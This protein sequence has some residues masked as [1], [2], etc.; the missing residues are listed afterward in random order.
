MKTKI[1]LLALLLNA[2]T[3]VDSLAQTMPLVYDVEN[4][5]AKCPIPYLPSFSELP[6]IPFYRNSNRRAGK[7]NTDRIFNRSELS[8]PVQPDD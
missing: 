2:Y 1:V 5:G 3:V 6:I 7:R 4:T 8:Q